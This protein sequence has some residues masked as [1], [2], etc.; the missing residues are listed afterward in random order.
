MI[1]PHAILKASFRAKVL[2]S[3]VVCL[4]AVM[5]ATLFIVDRFITQQSEREA[6]N[7]LTT[8]NSVL[9]NSEQARTHNLI[10]RFN[11]L[12]NEPRYRAA[13]NQGDPVTLQ[14]GPL[15]DLMTEQGVEVVFYAGLV[16]GALKIVD[17]EP[18]DPQLATTE[19]EKAAQ[20]AINQALQNQPEKADTV[21]VNQQLYDVIAIPAHDTD[22]TLMGVLVIGTRLGLTTAQE[23]SEITGSRIALMA[24][25]HVVASTTLIGP[26]MDEQFGSL[27]KNL[28]AGEPGDMTADVGVQSVV[29][30]GDPYYAT[31]GHFSSLGG[32]KAIGYVLLNSRAEALRSAADTKLRLLMAG[33]A[34]IVIGATVVWAL[35]KRVTQPLIELRDTAAAV[36]GGDFSRRLPVR[37]RDE[38]G[39]LASAFNEMTHDLQKSHAELEQTVTT[40]RNT[41][42]QLIQSE[43]LSAVGEFVAGVAHELNNPLAAVMGF[44]EML[45]DSD[46]DSKNRRHLE[47]IHKSAERC[48][49]IVQSLLSFARRQKPERKPV[50]VQQIVEAVLE[51]VSYPLRTSNI[52]V[53]T[54]FDTTV[55]YVH[56]DNHQIQQVVLNIINNARQAIEE[57]GA[58]PRGQIKIITEASAET[59]R[60]VIQ[61]NGPGIPEENLRRVFD[62][63][64]TTKKV[65]VGT[66]LGL[67]LCYGMVQEHGGSIMAMNRPDGGATFIIELPAMHLPGDTTELIRAEKNNDSAEDEGAGKRVLVI[68]DELAILDMLGESLGGFGY[69]VDKANDGRRAL[70]LLSKNDYHVTLC[71]W[72]MPGL[73]GRQVYEHLR[74]RKPEACRR[75]IFIS[76]DVVN[77]AMRGFLEQES[78]TC[79]SKPFTLGDVRE[80]I[81]SLTRQIEPLRKP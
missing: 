13:F 5:A 44:S 7:T 2:A 79:L 66:G 32:D 4:V 54:R 67:S 53:V 52:E 17:V 28:L 55:P 63:F 33:L 75:F 72:K 3:F 42:Q 14:K 34:A 46:P 80:A 27:F 37:G 58:C 30:D 47:I 8:A 23:F 73:N 61:D 70:D 9:L 10:L 11:R 15:T 62:P 45:K 24:S 76:G 78:R 43:K 35:I 48:Q 22:G 69:E 51:I 29:L 68:D 6:R 64:F 25:G 77:E 36:G 18:R 56:A 38:F 49:K 60:I 16:N 20:P 59:V 41:Q 31:A 26:K 71:D 1:N 74:D 50:Q 21:R 65:G 40:L 12:P 57:H 19:F 81:R 39:Q